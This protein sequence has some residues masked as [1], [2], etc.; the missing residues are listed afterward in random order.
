MTTSPRITLMQEDLSDEQL[1]HYLSQELIAI[2]G[3]MMG[4]NIHRDRLCLVQIGDEDRKI[5]LVQMAQG[6]KEAPNLKS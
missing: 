5:T 1:K 4:L 3:E 2:D 6:Q